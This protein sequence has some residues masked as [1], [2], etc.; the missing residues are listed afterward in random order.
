ML[1]GALETGT[2]ETDWEVSKVL[3]VMW[4]MFDESPTRRDNYIR[5]T[6]CDIFPLHFCK[7][8]R[9][10]DEHV[11]ERD[12]QIWGNI[13]QVVNYWR[14]LPKSKHLCNNLIH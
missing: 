11:A 13:V 7:I 1:H 4:K 2:M 3:H 8:M 12:I 14:S 5:E 6:G 9:V 10:E